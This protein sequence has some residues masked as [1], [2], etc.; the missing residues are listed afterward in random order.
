LLACLKVFVMRRTI[1]A[2]S[3]ILCSIPFAAA[4]ALAED[5]PPIA[6]QVEFFEKNVRPLLT[7]NCFECHGPEKQEA[8]LRL[9]SRQG[10]LDGGDSGPAV[11]PG[12][13]EESVLIKAISYNAEPKMPPKGKLKDDQIAVLTTWVKQGAVWPDSDPMLRASPPDDDFKITDK[14]RAFWSFQPPRNPALPDVRDTSWPKSSIDRFVLAE[15]ES[16]GMRPVAPA[17]KRTLIRRATFDLIGLPPTPEEVEAFVNDESPDA[18]AN[19]IDRLLAS[20]HYGERWARHWMDVARYGEDQAHSFK[21]Q[22]YPNGFRYRDWLIHAFNDDMP[23]DRFVMEQIA[24]D[25]LDEPGQ[26]ERLP[27]LGFFALGPVYY[28]DPKKLDQLDDRIDTLT[29]GFLGLTVAC[30]RCHDHKYDPIPT[31]DYYSLAGIFASTSYV[32]AAFAPPEVVEAYDR[33]QAPV[34]EHSKKIDQFVE[35]EAGRMARSMATADIARYMLAAWK[36]ENRRKTTAD[37]TTSQVAKD[38]GLHGF[39]LDSWVKYLA[40]PADTSKRPHLARWF[41]VLDRQDPKCDLSSN[42]QAAAETR[43]VA[44]AFQNYV[45]SVVKLRDALE[46]HRAAATALGVGQASRPDTGQNAGNAS[47]IAKPDLLN[48]AQIALLDEVIGPKGLFAIPKERIEQL[49]PAESKSQLT[50]MRAELD[51]MKKK[52]PP[53][54]PVTHS[55][56]ESAS[57]TNMKVHIRGNPDTLGNEAPRRFLSILAGND[58]PAFTTGSGRLELARAIA[59][60][61]NPLTARVL[62]NRIWQHHFGRGLVGTPSNFGALGERP[63]HPELLDFLASRFIASGWSMKRLHREIM[64]SATYQLSSRFD[65]HNHD[66]DPANRFLWRMNRRRLEVEAWRDAMLAVSGNL[67]PAV[68]GPSADLASPDNRRRTLYA[69]VSRHDLDWL[70]R[71]FDFPDPNITAAERTV[72]T[73]PLQQLFVLNSEFM[74]RNAKSLAARI[75]AIPHQDDASRVRRAILL[76]YGRPAT[77]RDI[78]LGLEFLAA[79]DSAAEVQQDN[80]RSD[81]TPWERYAQVVLSAN[82]FLFVD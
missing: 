45:R 7:A 10:A 43:E 50:S 47:Q 13:P 5:R 39:I 66:A 60:A 46:E 14:D 29:R 61:D 20:P 63:T 81:L 4:Y 33:A 51:Q 2:A 56:T 53:K 36:F 82:E 23:Y 34:E 8:G 49:M 11:V 65:A 22:L 21:P 27:A 40:R 74:V 71:L 30:A 3:A 17:D 26:L 31:R 76:L 57:V 19:V 59:R 48:D 9:D 78:R 35:T 80:G 73:V 44:E 28:G 69:A 18:F 41:E 54:Y 25:L 1:I 16:R 79:A 38:D 52:L 67:D 32:E 15:L 58:A 6:R 70:L 75:T 37:I 64:L 77:D 12:H 72:T 68:G 42:E 62:V 55:L 24:G